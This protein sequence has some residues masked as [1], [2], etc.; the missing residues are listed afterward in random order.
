MREFY[1]VKISLY[2]YQCSVHI[3]RISPSENVYLYLLTERYVGKKM[4]EWRGRQQFNALIRTE[5]EKLKLPTFLSGMG[6]MF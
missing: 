6:P 1:I 3:L 4:D 2:C 5:S